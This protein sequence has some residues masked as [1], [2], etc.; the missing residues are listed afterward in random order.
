MTNDDYE[1]DTI[2]TLEFPANVAAQLEK[3]RAQCGDELVIDLLGAACRRV[4]GRL[5]LHGVRNP[6]QG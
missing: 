5:A 1:D 6:H 2:I 3:L 4:E